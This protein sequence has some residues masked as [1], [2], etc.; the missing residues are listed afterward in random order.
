MKSRQKR[1]FP[2]KL[3][4]FSSAADDGTIHVFHATVYDDM[5]KNPMIVP[6]KKLT[7]HKVINSLGVLDAIWHPREAWLFSAGADNTARL[8]TT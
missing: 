3:P 2:Q 6:L 5:M 8:W 4:L 1:K 7:G